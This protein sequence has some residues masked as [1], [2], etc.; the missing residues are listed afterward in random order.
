MAESGSEKKLEFRAGEL[1]AAREGGCRTELLLLQLLVTE[2]L[3]KFKYNT[4]TQ[5]DNLAY[6]FLEANGWNLEVCSVFPVHL[7]SQTLLT[8]S[9]RDVLRKRGTF[10]FLYHPFASL[11][12]Q[13]WK[14]VRMMTAE[15]KTSSR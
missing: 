7:K 11:T 12:P 13:F 14:S 10:S 1:M 15:R 2:L 6:F 5:E 8:E 4:G 9:T 3:K